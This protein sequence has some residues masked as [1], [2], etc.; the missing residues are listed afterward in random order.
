MGEVV[1]FNAAVGQSSFTPPR[2]PEQVPHETYIAYQQAEAAFRALYFG[3]PFDLEVSKSDPC[4]K[5]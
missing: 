2:Q 1:F 3:R 4:V 5:I